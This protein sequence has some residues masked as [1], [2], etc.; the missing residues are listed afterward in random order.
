MF[1]AEALEKTK[2][3]IIGKMLEYEKQIFSDLVETDGLVVCA[4]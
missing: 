4:K 3:S 1:E 2:N